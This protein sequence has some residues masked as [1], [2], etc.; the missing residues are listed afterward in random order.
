[1]FLLAQGVPAGSWSGNGSD[2][3]SETKDVLSC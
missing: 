3:R 1:V 2:D